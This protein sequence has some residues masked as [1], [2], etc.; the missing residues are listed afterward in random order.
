VTPPPA[1]LVV[2]DLD[3]TLI[4]SAR[5]LA[6]AVNR[7]L[8]RIAPGTPALPDDVV[9]SF[10]G[11]GAR[12]LIERSLARTGLRVPVGDVL[13]VFLE[14]YAGCLLD[15]TRLYPGVEEALERLRDRRLAVLTNK[16]GDMS[17]AILAGLGVGDRFFRIAGGGD[18]PGQKPDPAGLLR[19]A[20]EAG[21]DP[22]DALMVGDSGID[23]RTGRAA[24]MPTAGVTYG[25]DAASF[26]EDPPDLLVDTLGEL[27][28]RLT[29]APLKTANTA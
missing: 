13:P 8:Q 22:A 15:T 24:G 17:R 19:L 9:R 5:D 28:H 14:A 25:F 16:P 12:V 18:F 3:G 6:T 29:V 27:A 21:V 2:F 26:R 11:S 23:V 10:I 1:R 20:A 4:D 7:A